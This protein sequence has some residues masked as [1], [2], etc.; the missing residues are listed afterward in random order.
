MTMMIKAI[1]AECA[2]G[3]AQAE[4]RFQA[5]AEH[6]IKVCDADCLEGLALAELRYQAKA[7]MAS[8]S[9]D[10]VKIAATA[11]ARNGAPSGSN[12]STLVA[13]AAM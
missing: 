4:R 3:M 9:A 11:V 7:K 5:L 10:I 8:R 12:D 13:A 1:E 6:S 2:E